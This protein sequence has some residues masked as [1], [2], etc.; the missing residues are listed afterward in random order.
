VHM[1]LY[2]MIHYYTICSLKL[3]LPQ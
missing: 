2:D 1:K 3:L